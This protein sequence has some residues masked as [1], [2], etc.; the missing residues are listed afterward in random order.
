MLV[1]VYNSE[2]ILFELE[3]FFFF[4]SFIKLKSKL[5]IVLIK[6]KVWNDVN[7]VN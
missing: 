3:F 5:L 4:D 6:I 1:V 2:F 7:K